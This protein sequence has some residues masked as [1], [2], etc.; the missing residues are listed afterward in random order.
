MKSTEILFFLQLAE[1]QAHRETNALFE[2]RRQKQQEAGGDQA[3]DDEEEIAALVSKYVKDI[4]NL[5][6]R[7]IQLEGEN[8]KLR[9]T[10]RRNLMLQHSFGKKY[11]S[12]LS[13]RAHTCSARARRSNA[14]NRPDAER[15]QHDQLNVRVDLAR[16]NGRGPARP[17]AK[18]LV[19]L[20]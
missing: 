19:Q 12:F 3:E 7:L 15:P 1:L 2:R 10:V 8:Q 18:R 6:T 4:E 20:S 9:R 16:A 13:E 11:V 14:D 5:R 17:A